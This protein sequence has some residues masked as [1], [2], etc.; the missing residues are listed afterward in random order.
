MAAWRPTT[1]RVGK[2][3]SSLET[4]P[5]AAAVQPCP[6]PAA[7]PP[8]ASSATQRGGGGGGGLATFDVDFGGSAI[9]DDR[10]HRTCG[11]THGVFPHVLPRYTACVRAGDATLVSQMKLCKDVR[12]HAC[13][14]HAR[15]ARALSSSNMGARSHNT[16]SPSSICNCQPH[17]RRTP[18]D[19]QPKPGR[20]SDLSARPRGVL[21]AC[22]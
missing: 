5:T 20:G 13:A 22:G 7:L 8:P 4:R 10:S 16:Q 21:A 17:H 1:R 18:E 15:A 11:S 9:V 19:E 6:A 12:V 2:L 14:R 3:A